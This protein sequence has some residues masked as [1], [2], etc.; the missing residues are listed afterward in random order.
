MNT[1]LF[2]KAENRQGYMKAGIMGFPGSGKSFTSTEIAIG[3]VKMTGDKRPVF[4]LDTEKGFDYLVERFKKEGVELYVART[5]AFVD[6][7]D[8]IKQAEKDASVLIIDSITHFW[9]E[10]QAAYKKKHNRT[11]L[12]FADWGP[13]KANWATYTRAY[14]DSRLHITMCGRAGDVY[15]NYLDEDGKRQIEKVGTKM[16]AEKNLGYEPGLGIEMER[17]SLGQ[18]KKGQRNFVNRAHIIKDR[19]D[20]LDGKF[21]D[22]PTFETFLPHIQKLNLGQHEGLS[23]ANSQKLFERD[24]SENWQQKR[25][26][27]EILK[28][29]IQG[30][31]TS[32]YPGRSAEDT[33][34]KTDLINDAFGTR[35]WSALDEMTPEELRAGLDVIK[36]QIA[37]LKSTPAVE[38][39][40]NGNN[41]KKAAEAGGK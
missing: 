36:A 16:Q 40:T 34:I 18:F 6:L 21:F 37:V 13:L 35:S 23:D 1:E 41:K 22:N 4:A 24:S 8:A 14:L 9:E 3:L 32:A 38:S 17:V 27:V 25:K 26:Q 12:T 28:E 5:R 30:E 10:V 29:E 15:D 2:K 7:L 33:K 39:T 19:F 31:L 11:S 20:V